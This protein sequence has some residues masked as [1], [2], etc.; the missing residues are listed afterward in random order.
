MDPRK[1]TAKSL[2]QRHDLHYFQRWTRWRLA[3]AALMGIVPALAGL[4]LLAYAVRR[5]STPYISGPLSSVHSFLGKRCDRCHSPALKAGM[6][7]VGFRRHVGDEACLSCHQAPAHHAALATFTPKCASCHLEHSGSQHLRQVTDESCVQCHRELKVR[8]GSPHFDTTIYNF[9]SRHPQFAPLR[10]GFRDPGT[11]KLNHAIHMRAGLLDRNAEPV[12]MRCQ[13][14]HRPPAE[15]S[16]PWKYGKP[17]VL[18]SGLSTPDEHNPLLPPDPIHPAT[19]RA[20]MAAPTYASACEGCH[21]LQ[22]DSHFGESVPHD[23][24]RVVRAFIVRKLTEY[25]RQ[26]PGAVHETARPMRIVFGGTILREPQIPKLAR[27]ADEWIKFR[28]EDAENLLWRKTCVQ[29]HTLKFG[30]T[31]QNGPRDLPEIIPANMSSI[32][33]PNSMFSHYAHASFDCKSCHI[34]ATASQQTSDVLIPSIAI[35]QQCHNGDPTKIGHA[36]NGC[37][38]CHQYHAWK[39]RSSPFVPVQSIEQLR[40]PLDLYRSFGF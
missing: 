12:Q 32:W 20:Y 4:W 35:C 13:D 27:N 30:E 5:N 34:R 36:E 2:G 39:E 38:L 28:A 23:K 25:V 1:R 31:D 17:R 6:I 7:N 16:E 37:F 26:H 29:C 15:Q 40:G 14:C 10:D 9:S 8:T 24:P 22:F 33:L 11:I 19:G 21:A 18:N 3:R